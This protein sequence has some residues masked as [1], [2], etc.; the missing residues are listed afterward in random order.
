MGWIN[1]NCGGLCSR[2]LDRSVAVVGRRFGDSSGAIRQRQCLAYLNFS[3]GSRP[4]PHFCAVGS[5]A[6]EGAVPP[7]GTRFRRRT[8]SG[9]GRVQEASGVVLACAAA[10]LLSSRPYLSAGETC[11]SLKT[12]R[13]RI[14]SSED[15]AIVF[16]GK[17]TTWRSEW[18]RHYELIYAVD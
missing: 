12:R 3:L 4:T 13:A 7:P 17:V 10:A 9:S 6:T 16:P 5:T 14:R 15:T 1:A 18:M 11:A 8:G 2:Q